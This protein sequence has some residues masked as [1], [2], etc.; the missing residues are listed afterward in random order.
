VWRR[1]PGGTWTSLGTGLPATGTYEATQLFDM[2]L[3]GAIDLVAFGRS[4]LTVWTGDGTGQ[5]T[6][7]ATLSTPTPGYRA[8]LRA[9]GDADHNGFPDLALMSEEGSTFNTRNRF[10]FY[11]E[12]TAAAALAVKPVRP[13]PAATLRAGAVAFIDWVS[14]VPGGAPAT[15][16]LELST[17]GPDGPWTSIAA[18]VPDGGRHQWIVPPVHAS[19]CRLRYTV[20]AGSETASAITAGSFTILGGAAA[21]ALGPGPP[22]ARPF[23]LTAQPNPFTLDTHIRF[24]AGARGDR[25]F[26]YDPRGCLVQVLAAP[27]RDG[28]APSLR[29][30]GRDTAGRPVPA[31]MYFIRLAGSEL[32]AKVVRSR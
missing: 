28:S 18:A 7:A 11:K 21:I 30:D 26:I 22:A 14:A 19:D 5:W 16:S 31:G 2:D 3:D 10:H 9:G 23:V 1:D 25:L 12:A 27:P 29:W 32:S 6:P 13:R 17:S 4:L 8:A 15:V 20:T 24:G